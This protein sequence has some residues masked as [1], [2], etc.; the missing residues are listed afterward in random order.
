MNVDNH[1]S[2]SE[3][4]GPEVLPG[5]DSSADLYERAA[6][7]KESGNDFFKQKRWQDAVKSYESAIETIL[8]TE[9]CS[10]GEGKN[11]L[12]TLHA[13]LAQCFLNLELYRRAI[14]SASVCLKLDSTNQKAL[15]RRALAY[16]HLGEAENA[17][18][19]LDAILKSDPT[20]SQAKVAHTQLIVRQ[21]GAAAD[22]A[23]STWFRDLNIRE[24]YEW[25]VDCYRLRLHDDCATKSSSSILRSLYVSDAS[26]ETVLEDWLVFCK[27]AAMC[28]AL[29]KDWSWQASLE[30]ASQPLCSFWGADETDKIASVAKTQLMREVAHRIYGDSTRQHSVREAV[31]SKLQAVDHDLFEDLGGAAIW[32]RFLR[33]L[34]DPAELREAAELADFE[35]GF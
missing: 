24:R 31:T 30:V 17:L 19:D 14:A 20:H 28:F 22:G 32:Q 2:C 6:D 23:I 25:F 8:I 7:L 5:H 12:I 27:L 26:R 33:R 11:L 4:P 13:N 35:E 15:F 18:F 21:A 1:L 16:E 34:P 3:Q 29:P 10:A 9:N